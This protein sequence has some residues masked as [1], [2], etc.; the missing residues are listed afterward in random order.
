M[1]DLSKL[2]EFRA[3]MYES[4]FPIR[5]DA[6]LNLIDAISANG[7][8]CRS[9]TEL[10]TST[11]FPRQYPSITDVVASGSQH[12]NKS[13]M[14]KLVYKQTH[15]E[16]ERVAFVIDCTPQARPTAKCLKDKHIVYKPNPAPGN[17]PICVGHEYSIVAALPNSKGS[18]NK[19]WLV[20][21]STERVSSHQKGNQVGMA[22]VATLVEDLS[23]HNKFVISIADSKYGT[24]GCLEH[25]SEHDNWVHLHRLNSTRNI[26]APVTRLSETVGNKKRY[27]DV[28]KLNNSDTHRAP[29]EVS[30]EQHTT[31]SGRV[32][33]LTIKR[34]F[35]YMVRGSQQYKGYEHPFDV[36][37]VTAVD[38]DGRAIYKNPLWIAVQGKR[39]VELT[40]KEIFVYYHRRYDIEHY[41]RF[42]KDKLLF[43]SFQTPTAEHEEY[44]WHLTSL[45]YVQLYLAREQITLLPKPWERY[46]DNYKS[47]NNVVSVA[48]PSQ[49]QRAFSSILNKIG[50]P[51]KL[52][53]KRGNPLGRKKGEFQ[54]KR[55]LHP[56]YYKSAK[57]NETN[58][59][60]QSDKPVKLSDSV[61]IDELLNLVDFSLQ[62]M[63][64]ST[65]DF[66]QKLKKQA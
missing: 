7:H 65:D 31:A 12:T 52:P 56:V 4:H 33:E 9:V 1:V 36:I 20:P 64:I 28:M 14:S 47:K 57:K 11:H 15:E 23:L 38:K 2:T 10:S 8:C 5:R 17:K 24:Q 40:T 44:W 22:Q 45:A 25:L 35:N 6:H 32:Y 63:K 59:S 18:A 34:W 58:N 30:T 29:D 41:F 48:T 19:H 3:A 54:E 66:F 27:G 60:P 21:L 42:G 49:T 13:A 26:Y 43:A 39:R 46:L 61:E 37:Q 53:V 50:T 16:T 62:K 51:A 55:T